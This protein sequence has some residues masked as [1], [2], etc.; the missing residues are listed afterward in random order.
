M[1][2][3]MKDIR[4]DDGESFWYPTTLQTSRGMVYPEGTSEK[5]NWAYTPIKELTKEESEKLSTKD[6]VYES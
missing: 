2:Q 4:F 1:P 6:A 3:L 5:W